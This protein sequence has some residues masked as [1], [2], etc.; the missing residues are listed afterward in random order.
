VKLLDTPSGTDKSTGHVHG[1]GNPH[2]QT[3]ARNFLPIARAISERLIV[4]DPAHTSHYQDR[5][6]MFEISWKINIE[7]WEM[8]ARPL[9]GAKIWVQHDAFVYL[10]AWLSMD[11]VGVLE[12]VSG[13]DPSAAN[14]GA[15]L[16]KQK[17]VNAK[18]ILAPVY[19]NQNASKWLSEKA[20]IPLAILPFTVGG[21]A[22]SKTLESLFDDTIRRLLD[23]WKR[24]Q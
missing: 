1:S 24:R 20:G 4:L 8:Q 12:A 19:Q 5:L 7:K 17:A 3:D 10:N 9:S 2:I 23:A 22:E 16:E 15:I 6:Q 14:L 11:Q 18:M 13:V 21:N